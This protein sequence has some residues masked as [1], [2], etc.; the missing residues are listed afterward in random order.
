MLSPGAEVAFYADGP[1]N[2]ALLATGTFAG[3]VGLEESEGAPL[4]KRGSIYRT[5]QP[6]RIRGFARLT[7]LRLWPSG[8]PVDVLD[9]WLASG[10]RLA[11]D[12]LP[13][14]HAA[15]SIYYMRN[16]V[17]H[18][19]SAEEKLALS[20]AKCAELEDKYA[21]VRKLWEQ[22]HRLQKRNQERA[23][24]DLESDFEEEIR[25][26]RK[27]SGGR[28]GQVVKTLRRVLEHAFPRLRLIRDS[29]ECVILNYNDCPSLVD[30][31]ATLNNDPL[32]LAGLSRAK[33]VKGSPGLFEVRF[34]DNLGRL[35][36]RRVESDGQVLV[37]VLV[38][39]K[40]EQSLDIESL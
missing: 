20:E 15:A 16:S 7:S 32:H 34:G 39:Q 13:T 36:Y 19:I 24:A 30:D 26:R 29:A 37:H 8:T 2:R 4:F 17:H 12:T 35:Y 27:P 31:L 25:A 21:D 3:F 40:D 38:S 6:E 23:L 9:G 22:D 33:Q 11:E 1:D 5:S 14:G 18:G 10:D 28:H